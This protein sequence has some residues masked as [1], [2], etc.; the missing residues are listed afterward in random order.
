MIR[1]AIVE[2]HVALREALINLLSL[3]GDVRVVATAGNRVEATD[4]VM[5]RSFDVLLLDLMLP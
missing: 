5:A 2:A 4:C 1:V 3:D